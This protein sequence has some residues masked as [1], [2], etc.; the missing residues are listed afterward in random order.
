M[1]FLGETLIERLIRRLAPLKAET[2]IT[3]NQAETYRFLGLPLFPDRLPGSG[4]LGGLL[5][6]IEAARTPLVAV[7]ACD[8]P[9]ASSRLA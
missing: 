4:A 6:A 5:T 9:F 8:M 7:V 1:T 2:F 3:T